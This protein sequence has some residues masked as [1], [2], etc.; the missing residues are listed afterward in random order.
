MIYFPF[1]LPY[2]EAQSCVFAP[3][4]SEAEGLVGFPRDDQ[5]VDL[6]HHLGNVR[7]FSSEINSALVSE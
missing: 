4:D 7:F 3:D 6:L 5:I 2:L 1:F